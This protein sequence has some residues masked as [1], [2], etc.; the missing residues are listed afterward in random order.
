MDVKDAF[1]K[2]RYRLEITKAEEDDASRRHQEV[3]DYLR[4]KLDVTDDFLTG[5]YIRNTKT[6]PLKDVDVFVVLGDVTDSDDPND[7]LLRVHDV[8]VEKY[9][10][11]RVVTD[12]PAVRVDFGPEN[13]GAEDKVMTIEVVPAIAKGSHYRIADPA[14]RGW[15]ST[16]PKVHATLTTDANKAFSGNWKP[17]V[18]MIKAWNRDKGEP[19]E[20]S[21]LIEVMA[22][23]LVR[24]EW[25]GSFPREIRAFFASASERIDET[26]ADPAGLGSPVSDQLHLDPL[27][28]EQARVALRDAERQCGEAIRLEQKTGSGAANDAWQNLFGPLF[29]KS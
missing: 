9:G 11:S 7:V 13:A 28:L 5:S 26:W 12:R 10:D 21:F 3:R 8:L 2:F 6:K 17:L 24:G 14:R 25:T 15:M 22:L 16:D 1:D 29:A 18:K 23:N 20:P 4:Q 27:P 19:I